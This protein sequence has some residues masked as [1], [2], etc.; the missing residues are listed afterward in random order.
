MTAL[1]TFN[2]PIIEIEVRVI[3][4]IWDL[5]LSSSPDVV[6]SKNQ[7]EYQYKVSLRG[8]NDV[9]LRIDFGDGKSNETLIKDAYSRDDFQMTG[10]Y[11]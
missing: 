1:N 4:K 2:S 8:G 11:R 10:I 7:Y 3:S 5:T 9:K 6:S